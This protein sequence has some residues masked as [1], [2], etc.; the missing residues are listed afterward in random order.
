MTESRRRAAVGMLAALLLAGGAWLARRPDPDVTWTRVTVEGEGGARHP[1]LR[2]GPRAG[3]R[4]GTALLAHGVTASKETLAVVAEALARE[5]FD[6]VALDLPGHGESPVSLRAPGAMTDAL[7][8][9][10]RALTGAPTS[11]PV[12]EPASGPMVD[13]IVGHSMGAHVAGRALREGRV[14]ARAFVA[15]GAVPSEELPVARVLLLTGRWDPLATPARVE[16]AARSLPRVEARLVAADHVTEP[17]SPAAA[18]AVVG[19]AL[20]AVGVTPIREGLGHA[21]LLRAF[22]AA[23]TLLAL[24][25]AALGAV[26]R[27]PRGRPAALALGAAAGLIVVSVTVVALDGAWVGLSPRPRHVVVYP[28]LALATAGASWVAGVLVGRLRPASGPRAAPLAQA[29]FL[30]ATLLLAALLAV[31]GAR[32]FALMAVLLAGVLVLALL[33][34]AWAARA[35]GRAEAGHVAWALV[36]AYWPALLITLAL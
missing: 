7:V 11:E 1:A 3:A 17:W 21:A 12:S 24:P 2:I 33:T 22:G 16:A 8:A 5:G 20:A 32:F 28:P 26:P 18:R 13:L 9:G 4:R 36:V 27:R 35:T 10:A 25:V 30:A 15:L 19:E 23:L 31:T 14:R 6:C 29:G 34:G